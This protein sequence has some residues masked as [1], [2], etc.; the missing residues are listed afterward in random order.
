VAAQIVRAV[1]KNRFL[2]ITSP[3]IRVAYWFKRK[4]FFVYHIIMKK[5]NKMVTSAAA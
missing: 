5:L 3:D 4:L 2:V 1:K